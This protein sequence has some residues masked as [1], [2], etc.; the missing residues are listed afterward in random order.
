MKHMVIAMKLSTGPEDPFGRSIIQL[1][2]GCVGFCLVFESKKTA[3]EFW[4]NNVE[5]VQIKFKDGSNTKK[6]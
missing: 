4:G 6:S 2:K 1:P 5:F 3:K